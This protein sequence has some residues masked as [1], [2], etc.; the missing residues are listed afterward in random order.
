ALDYDPLT[1]RQ[2]VVLTPGA[3]EFRETGQTWGD[4]EMRRDP[5]GKLVPRIA[6]C[7]VTMTYLP[8][9]GE[10]RTFR[11]RM[12]PRSPD[13]PPP[14]APSLPHEKALPPRSCVDCHVDGVGNGPVVLP[15]SR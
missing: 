11:G 1:T 6:G 10:A 13:Y 8:D 4:P 5:D 7:D 14:V 12:N 2:R 15:G 9:R 3:V